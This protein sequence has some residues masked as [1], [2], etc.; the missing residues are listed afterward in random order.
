MIRLIRYRASRRGMK[1]LAKSREI[2]SDLERR[3]GQVAQL[4][5]AAYDSNPPKTGRVRV[6]VLN[7][8]KSDSDRARVAVIARHPIAL[9][10]ESQSR[11]LGSAINAAR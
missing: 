4:A 7:D 3:A 2:D 1:I 11:I 9:R 8:S 10:I 6:E 5:Q